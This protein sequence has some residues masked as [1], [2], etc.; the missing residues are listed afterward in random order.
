MRLDAVLTTYSTQTRAV[1][2]SAVGKLAALGHRFVAVDVETRTLVANNALEKLRAEDETDQEDLVPED[3]GRLRS[4]E[5]TSNVPRV[6]RNRARAS[7]VAVLSGAA[8]AGVW[9]AAHG[10]ER[11]HCG[12]S[13]R[14]PV[15]DERPRPVHQLVRQAAARQLL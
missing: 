10:G 2:L 5:L 6:A 4:S 12:R 9:H 14:Q 11:D 8:S 15:V 7:S 3:D 1:W 13:V